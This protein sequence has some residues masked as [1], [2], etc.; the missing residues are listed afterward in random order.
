[1]CVAAGKDPEVCTRP[2][3]I[4]PSVPRKSTGHCRTLTL[5][6]TIERLPPPLIKVF[7]TFKKAASVVNVG[8]ATGH[9]EGMW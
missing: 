4:H 6:W 7:G 1:M 3:L 5:V 2:H 8:V 9:F